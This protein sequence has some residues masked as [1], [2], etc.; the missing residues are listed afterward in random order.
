MFFE[1]ARMAVIILNAIGTNHKPP[2]VNP[3]LK[4]HNP[5]GLLSTESR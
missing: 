1:Y 5:I 2:N 4:N 3:I